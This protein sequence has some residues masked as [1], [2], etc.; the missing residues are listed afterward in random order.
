MQT[1]NST[2]LFE[3]ARPRKDHRRAGEESQGDHTANGEDAP[4][5]VR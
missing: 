5:S 2:V 3:R 4:R 1:N